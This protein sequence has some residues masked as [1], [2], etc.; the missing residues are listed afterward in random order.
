M[1]AVT[2]W[3]DQDRLSSTFGEWAVAILE[4]SAAIFE[5]LHEDREA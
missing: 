4:L 2:E 1:K 5:K 3:V